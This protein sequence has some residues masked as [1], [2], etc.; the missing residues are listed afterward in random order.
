MNVS[1]FRVTYHPGARKQLDKIEP[2]K[3]RGQIARR[4]DALENN[5]M[6]DNAKKLSQPQGAFRLRQGEYRIIYQVRESQIVILQIGHRR[7]VYR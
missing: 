5:P 1:P 3:I 4:I 7:D 6:P 2:R